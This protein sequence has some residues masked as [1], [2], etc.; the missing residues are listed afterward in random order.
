MTQ[1]QTPANW[2]PDPSDSAQWRYWDGASW[3]DNVAPREVVSNAPVVDAALPR[4]PEP[5]QAIASPLAETAASPAVAAPA[6]SRSERRTSETTFV[7]RDRI[8]SG[9]NRNRIFAVAAALGLLTLGAIALW[10]NGS[11]SEPSASAPPVD[12]A[13]VVGQITVPVVFKLQGSEGAPTFPTPSSSVANSSTLVMSSPYT[14]QS[15]LDVGPLSLNSTATAYTSS[16]SASLKSLSIADTRTANG[17]YTVRATASD[18]TKVGV[19]APSINEIVHAQN[20][21]LTDI[22]LVN[23]TATPPTFISKQ[24]SDAAVS[25][26]N[27]VAYENPAALQV[28]GNAT[29]SAGLGSIPHPVLHASSGLGTTEISGLVSVAA[30]P[31]TLDGLYAGTI[32][33]TIVE[34]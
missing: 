15:P 11:G 17:P 9:S 5:T 10:F 32:T 4:E 22:K 24:T 3:T 25:K 6:Q 30:P 16:V 31:N 21:G 12:T 26:T 13:T 14:S 28:A 1:Q 2:Y 19:D 34:E 27:L 8:P 20:I 7:P 18:F 29:G 33:F 23:T